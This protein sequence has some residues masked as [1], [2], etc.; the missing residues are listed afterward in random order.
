VFLAIT[1]SAAAIEA[2]V[3]A[4]RQVEGLLR[5]ELVANLV[6]GAGN[7]QDDV[8]ASIVT[9]GALRRPLGAIRLRQSP[10]SSRTSASPSGGPG[11]SGSRADPNEPAIAWL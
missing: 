3:K 9:D 11:G 10:G 1:A 5:Q 8:F 4:L 6:V 2:Q 7:G